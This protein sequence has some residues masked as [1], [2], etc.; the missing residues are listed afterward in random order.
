M[1]PKFN[2]GDRVQYTRKD[3]VAVHGTVHKVYIKSA[4]LTRQ[5]LGLFH[6][7]QLLGEEVAYGLRLSEEHAA[8]VG[9]PV[10]VGETRL[11]AHG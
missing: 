10:T 1:T 11:S 3:G 6:N 5:E 2:P 8:I 4:C 9:H 7:L